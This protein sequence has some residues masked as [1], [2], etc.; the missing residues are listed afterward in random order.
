MLL[1]HTKCFQN[2]FKYAKTNSKGL[3]KVYY[4][5]NEKVIP[6]GGEIYLKKGYHINVSLLYPSTFSGLR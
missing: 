1:R 6:W 4:I 3:V 5:Y 2:N